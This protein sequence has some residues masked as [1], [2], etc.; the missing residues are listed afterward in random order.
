MIIGKINQSVQDLLKKDE[1]KEIDEKVIKGI[2]TRQTNERP[3][4]KGLTDTFHP[5]W[6]YTKLNKGKQKSESIF[7]KFKTFVLKDSSE[8]EDMIGARSSVNRKSSVLDSIEH[9]IEYQK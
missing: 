4:I 3:P 8:G 2:F 5:N 6:Y 7:K 9:F 1:F